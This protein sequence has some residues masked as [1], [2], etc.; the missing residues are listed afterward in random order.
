MHTSTWRVWAFVRLLLLGQSA[1]SQLA[2]SASRPLPRRRCISRQRR[3]LLLPVMKQPSKTY[4]RIC[5][6]LQL[7]SRCALGKHGLKLL[8]VVRNTQ[9][10]IVVF[11][12]VCSSVFGK[13]RALAMKHLCRRFRQLKIQWPPL[14][15]SIP[16]P[17]LGSCFVSRLKESIQDMVLQLFSN[18][19]CQPTVFTHGKL[20]VRVRW[21]PPPSLL[22]CVRSAPVFNKHMDDPAAVTCECDQSRF[23]DFPKVF[24]PDGSVHVCAK[25]CDLPW[26]HQFD[27][28]RLAPVQT[29]IVPSGEWASRKLIEAF[30]NLALSVRDPFVL[31]GCELEERVNQ[32]VQVVAYRLSDEWVSTHGASAPLLA[33]SAEHVAAA[34]K[35][36]K[37]LYVEVL[38]KNPSSFAAM[39]PYLA[40]QI[41]A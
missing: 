30:M 3:P 12:F 39:C 22:N 19:W 40:Q 23:C 38:D 4:Q 9:L 16:L 33:L 5:R 26:P 11:R 20:R 28:L 8:F 2:H 6:T 25:Q 35:L 37:G 18:D 31:C 7:G 14:S 29:P 15:V 34:R 10:V 36:C 21:V 1:T 13:R 27:I 24:G 41:A 32:V 17:W